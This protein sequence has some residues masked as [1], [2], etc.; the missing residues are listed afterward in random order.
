MPKHLKVS[1]AGFGFRESRRGERESYGEVLIRPHVICEDGRKTA[2]VTRENHGGVVVT[3][4]DTLA[5]RE[6]WGK[7]L[8]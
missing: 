3:L 4:M 7:D 6:V 1:N 2:W 5:G 8:D